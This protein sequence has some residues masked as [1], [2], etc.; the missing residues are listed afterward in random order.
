MVQSFSEVRVGVLELLQFGLQFLHIVF[1]IGFRR[2]L[3][4]EVLIH[5]WERLLLSITTPILA[6]SLHIHSQLKVQLQSLRNALINSC[7]GK[8]F[9]HI[10]T[11]G[12]RSWHN[13]TSET[14]YELWDIHLPARGRSLQ[15]LI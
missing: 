4:F 12:Y 1:I 15:R 3:W 14:K 8:G 6:L 2:F 7:C 9:S 10:G 5:E 11:I 13:Q